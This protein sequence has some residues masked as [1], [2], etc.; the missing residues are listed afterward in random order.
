MS[1]RGRRVMVVRER[2]HD[3]VRDKIVVF[4]LL[5]ARRYGRPGAR[6]MRVLAASDHGPGE[7]R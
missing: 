1:A 2:L 5:C 3:L 6:V 7:V 4:P